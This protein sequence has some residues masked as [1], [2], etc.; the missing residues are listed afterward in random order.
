MKDYLFETSNHVLLKRNDIKTFS[1]NHTNEWEAKAQ[2][3]LIHPIQTVR[4]INLSRGRHPS[5]YRSFPKHL[6]QCLHSHGKENKW[7][8]FKE[9]EKKRERER[10]RVRERE[11]DGKKEGVNGET[12][13]KKNGERR[14]EE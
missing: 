4:I 3:T 14:E 13:M 9:R 1:P 8:N 7:K 12:K 5:A 10:E 2:C 11:R 6:S